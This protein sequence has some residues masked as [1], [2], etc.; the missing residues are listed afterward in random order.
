MATIDVYSGAYSL[1][2]VG[3]AYAGYYKKGTST[4]FNKVDFYGVAKFQVS[5]KDFV[6][7]G[8]TPESGRVTGFTVFDLDGSIR[9]KVSGLDLSVVDFKGSFS[10]IT[11]LKT[12]FKPITFRFNGGD[13]DD[14]FAGG[15]GKD[16]VYGGL[17]SDT[18]SGNSQ[19]DILHGGGANSTVPK[20]IDVLDYSNEEGGVAIKVDL[21][22]GTVKDTFGYIDTISAFEII[23]GTDGN[24]TFKAS[25][26]DVF[27]GFAGGSGSNVFTGGTG[28]HDAVFYDRSFG[29]SVEID[30][31]AN[32]DGK[33][34]AISYYGTDTLT[35]IEIV[36]GSRYSD[37]IY[38]SK[39]NES[40]TGAEGDDIL[41]GRGGVDTI[42][43]SWE[44][45]SYGAKVNLSKG[46]GYDTFADRDT[47]S[48]FENVIGSRSND[49]LTGND[50]AN[51]LTGGYG[52]DTLTGVSG[53]DSLSGGDGND[54]LY[55][56]TGNDALSGGAG[57]DI[58]VFNAA[59]SATTNV[60]TISDFSVVSD[61]I[62]LENAIF[63][64]ITGTGVLTSAQFS[65]NAAGTAA[66][67]SDR[68]I[69]ETDTGKLFYDSNGNASGGS[70]Q[71]AQ[72]A[73]G[74]VLTAADFYII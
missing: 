15:A 20:E 71:F 43:Y 16:T 44:T 23:I 3:K 63:T 22:T 26:T 49:A 50:M 48:N 4:S 2:E 57:N 46:Y 6:Y 11:D 29:A 18:I 31:A 64:K 60:D 37:D 12:M 67:T 34:L 72:L 45:G 10:N 42:D 28:K 52:N 66:D 8:D 47:L 65:A 5:G 32:G 1:E 40:V 36:V 74:L 54:I 9:Y 38:G 59:L 69:Y 51:K 53:N 13:S 30:L 68:I 56:G 55:G 61:T 62:K 24:D 70:V 35:G 14:V 27:Q 25:A 19:S 17:G 58:F 39:Y 21:T 33:G 73:K 7:N 41:D